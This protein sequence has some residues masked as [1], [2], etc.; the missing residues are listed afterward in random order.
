MTGCWLQRITGVRK[1]MRQ[2]LDQL[3]R[4]RLQAHQPRKSTVQYLGENLDRQGLGRTLMPHNK[5][6]FTQRQ[7]GNELRKSCFGY[8]CFCSLGKGKNKRKGRKQEGGQH[9]QSTV[10]RAEGRSSWTQR[11]GRRQI[12]QDFKDQRTGFGFHSVQKASKKQKDS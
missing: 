10:N 8:L 3:L 7:E 11:S 9:D 4:P 1:V 5:M 2:M 6:I 12:M